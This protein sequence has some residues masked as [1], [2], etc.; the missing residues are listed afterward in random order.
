MGYG[1]SILCDVAKIGIHPATYKHFQYGIKPHQRH[2]KRSRYKFSSPPTNSSI[3]SAHTSPFRQPY[4][5]TKLQLEASIQVI[6][7]VHGR[8][9]GNGLSLLSLRISR[10]HRLKLLNRRDNEQVKGISES[11]PQD[12]V[13]FRGKSN[14]Y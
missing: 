7:A 5:S 12:N 10:Y 1:L 9:E 13:K 2:S 4:T 8:L 6:M 14:L 11:H 3:S